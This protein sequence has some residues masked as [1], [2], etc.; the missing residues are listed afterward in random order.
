M[1]GP[2]DSWCRPGRGEGKDEYRSS[3]DS[4]GEKGALSALMGLT[5]AVMD[6]CSADIAG[7]RRRKSSVVLIGEN[8]S[9]VVQGL[10]PALSFLG[11]LDR[12]C[13]KLRPPARESRVIGG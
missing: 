8:A 6:S 9:D 7:N 12:L 13:D 2:G 11:V 5:G 3:C 1:I 4:P 10:L